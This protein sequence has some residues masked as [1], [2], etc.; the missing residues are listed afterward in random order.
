MPARD[1]GAVLHAGAD[2]KADAEDRIQHRQR[3]GHAQGQAMRIAAAHR[4]QHG[5]ARGQRRAPGVR[6]GIEAQQRP[7][8]AD[9]RHGVR[10]GPVQRLR[11][12]G[13]GG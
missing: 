3:L 8:P 6:C 11:A 13:T 2:D 5:G 10:A 4:H 9:A 7:F 1:L 12:C